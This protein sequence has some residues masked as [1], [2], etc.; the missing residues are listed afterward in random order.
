MSGVGR[1]VPLP[2]TWSQRFWDSLG[3]GQ[4]LL[5]RCG[6]CAEYQGYPKVFCTSCYSDNLEWVESSGLGTVYTY[7]T[8]VAN[9]PSAFAEDLPYTLAIVTLDEGPR[10]LARLVDVAPQDVRCDLAVELVLQQVDADHVMPAFRPAQT[11]DVRG[12]TGSG[13]GRPRPV[14]PPE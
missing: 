1:P 3:E 12:S 5:Q 8:I 9:P 7:T 13:D 11:E 14:P 6:D 2:T 10:F 4:F